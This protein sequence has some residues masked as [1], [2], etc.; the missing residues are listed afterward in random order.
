MMLTK[1][2]NSLTYNVRSIG[3]HRDLTQSPHRDPPYARRTVLTRFETVAYWRGRRAGI[4]GSAIPQ[5]PHL[6]AV[7]GFLRWW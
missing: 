4:P 7:P 6:G 3:T 5:S 1:V 2:V